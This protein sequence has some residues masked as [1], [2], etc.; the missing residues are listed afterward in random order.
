M[1]SRRRAAL[2]ELD[3]SHT[4]TLH[5]HACMLARL[6][7]EVRLFVRAEAQRMIGDPGP[8]C[9]VET[10]SVDASL[11]RAVA[12]V[13]RLVRRLRELDVELVVFNT[14]EG[15]RVRNFCLLA[16]SAPRCIGVLHNAHKLGASFTQAMIT[17]RMAGY[18]VLSESIAANLGEARVPVEPFYPIEFPPQPRMPPAEGFEVVVP[19]RIDPARRDYAALL[20]AV[21]GGGLDPRVRVVLLGAA[22]EHGRSLHAAFAALGPQVEVADG[23][24][25]E[26][27]L[28]QQ[29]Q[30]AALILPLVTPRCTGFARYRTSK[31]SGAFSLSY[32]LGVPMLNHAA[33]A[34]IAELQV[35]SQFHEDGALVERLN[36]LAAAPDELAVVRRRIAAYP[37]FAAVG[38]QQRYAALA[39]GAPLQALRAT[40]SS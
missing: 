25:A 8:V 26:A 1:M 29:V 27:T 24:V 36:A 30:R 16:G 34:G 2:I 13:R 14:A 21:R 17:R 3:G 19:G 32:G 33:L 40:T 20:E 28:L 7:W 11:W 18:F 35:A 6:G 37:G 15:R 9:A 5:P 38:Q 39:G 4:E 12:E 31:I 23:F 10:H 22:S